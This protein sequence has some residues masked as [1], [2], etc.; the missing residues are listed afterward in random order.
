MV[1]V[2]QTKDVS[3]C[4]T[5]MAPEAPATSQKVDFVVCIYPLVDVADRPATLDAF[6]R[7]LDISITNWRNDHPRPQVATYQSPWRDQSYGS[8]RHIQ[9]QSENMVSFAFS[10]YFTICANIRRIG[11][12]HI[13]AAES[14]AYM[15]VRIIEF[16]DEYGTKYYDDDD[17]DFES[18]W[19]EFL[20]NHEHREH[21]GLSAENVISPLIRCVIL[22]QPSLPAAT[23]MARILWH[24][25]KPGIYGHL[26]WMQPNNHDLIGAG[27]KQRSYG[28]AIFNA[29]AHGTGV[30]AEVMDI[31]QHSQFDL[32]ILRIDNILVD[33]PK[34][35]CWLE[36]CLREAS[37]SDVELRVARQLRHRSSA[38]GVIRPSNGHT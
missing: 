25:V 14:C 12:I 23:G 8:I 30:H 1:G 31:P 11:R 19:I 27:S 17:D 13:I 36:R 20:V 33:E 7:A 38:G 22:V 37:L 34:L 35:C 28:V 24:W 29:N 32:D 5:E 2:D 15:A 9:N 21:V 4:S 26:E 18:A 10:L 6:I 16:L 3:P